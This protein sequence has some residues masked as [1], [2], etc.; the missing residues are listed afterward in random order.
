MRKR[1]RPASST[2]LTGSLTALKPPRVTLLRRRMRARFERLGEHRVRLLMAARR[3][4]V[5]GLLLVLTTVTLVTGCGGG[6]GAASTQSR[7]QLRHLLGVLRRGST[8]ADQDPALTA[9]LASIAGLPNCHGLEADRG[10]IRLATVT[11]WGQKVF[12]VAFMPPACTQPPCTGT[13]RACAAPPPDQE[14][15]R[16]L[17]DSGG[18]PSLD[19]YP[20][21]YWTPGQVQHGPGVVQL[22]GPRAGML[23]E[24]L[25]VPDGVR[26]V[27]VLF[28]RQEHAGGVPYRRGLKVVV[29]VHSNVAAVQVERSSVGEA[30]V[31]YGRS[32]GPIM[33]FGTSARL[34]G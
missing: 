1:G 32:G 3:S 9:R 30:V 26:R 4:R 11:P 28:A 12:V 8:P 15:V 5:A 14:T 6:T 34:G 20:P 23:R 21:Q 18:P 2:F 27:A 31:W 33:R 22:A 24:L 19:P 13:A 25:L 7:R 29:P 10:L 16:L 17:S